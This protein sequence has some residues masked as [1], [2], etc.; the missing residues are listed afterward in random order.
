MK[1]IILL[2]VFVLGI[3]S[4]NAQMNIAEAQLF[5]SSRSVGVVYAAVNQNSIATESF[6]NNFTIKNTDPYDLTILSVSIPQGVSILLP[7]E[8]IPAGESADVIA[9]IYKKYLD[10]SDFEKYIIVN[11]AEV[12]TTENV[13]IQKVFRL[14]LTGDFAE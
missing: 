6:T 10:S 5:G 12:S 8:I 1:K 9:T 2:S 13:Y 4:A 11:A 7:Q 14:K 3:I